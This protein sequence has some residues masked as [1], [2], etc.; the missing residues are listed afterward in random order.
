MSMFRCNAPGEYNNYAPRA[1]CI[2]NMLL[3][4][5]GPGILLH[6]VHA[7][8]AYSCWGIILGQN[9]TEANESHRLKM[10]ALHRLLC[11]IFKGAQGRLGFYDGGGRGRGSLSSQNPPTPLSIPIPYVNVTT[12]QHL[13]TP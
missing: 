4:H 9:L 7:P 11:N 13:D 6:I 8:G 5:V 10:E 1:T 12:F 3:E 2:Q